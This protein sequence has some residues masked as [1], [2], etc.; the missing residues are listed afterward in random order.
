LNYFPASFCSFLS[1]WRVFR[2]ALVLFITNWWFHFSY[3]E[4]KV[5]CC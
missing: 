2:S 3:L 4:L 5:Q 1:L